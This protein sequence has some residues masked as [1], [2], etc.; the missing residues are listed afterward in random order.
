MRKLNRC[1]ALLKEHAAISCDVLLNL[2]KTTTYGIGNPGPD[3]EQTQK[4]G[5]KFRQVL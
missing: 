2:K 5:V 3:L 1:V 4:C